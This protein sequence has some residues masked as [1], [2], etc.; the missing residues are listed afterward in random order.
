MILI[1][2]YYTF[3]VINYVYD[4]LHNNPTICSLDFIEY[5]QNT[6]RYLMWIC[7]YKIRETSGMWYYRI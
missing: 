6:L 7:K 4:L 5:N 2:T 1:E 3:C